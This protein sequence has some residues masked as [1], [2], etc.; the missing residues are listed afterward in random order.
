M[1]TKTYKQELKHFI[2]RS[3]R[4]LWQLEKVIN[5]IQKYVSSQLQFSVLGK[6]MQDYVLEDDEMLKTKKRITRVLEKL[7]GAYLPIWTFL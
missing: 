4:H 1:R 7:L 5:E 2:I 6:S 3:Y